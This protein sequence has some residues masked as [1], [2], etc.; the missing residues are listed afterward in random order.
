MFLEIIKF[1]TFTSA[2]ERKNLRICVERSTQNDLNIKCIHIAQFRSS[3]KLYRTEAA[4]EENQNNKN[5]K[6]KNIRRGLHNFIFPSI[7]P[8]SSFVFVFIVVLD[9]G[10]ATP[11]HGCPFGTADTVESEA[12]EDNNEKNIL[13]I[14]LR[15]S[16]TGLSA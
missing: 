5:E 2:E 13:K 10:N 12:T 9:V 4:G 7:V 15:P 3:L 16:I 14:K 1:I 6:R 11:C 8:S